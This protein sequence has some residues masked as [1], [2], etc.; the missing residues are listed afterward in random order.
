[1]RGRQAKAARA[2]TCS[3]RVPG[4]AAHTLLEGQSDHQ[5]SAARARRPPPSPCP[6]RPRR[7]NEK[8]SSAAPRGS[9]RWRQRTAAA[10]TEPAVGGEGQVREGPWEVQHGDAQSVTVGGACAT[11]TARRHARVQTHTQPGAQQCPT[12]TVPS[13][14]RPPTH[15][16]ALVVGLSKGGRRL[17]HA[18]EQVQGL[19]RGGG[20]GGGH[21]R[22]CD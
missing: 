13:I 17:H 8:D 4:A 3:G 22:A 14:R 5:R 21:M 1:M 16:G 11:Q 7:Q 19:G 20:G 18:I 2:G 9:R 12:T 10:G 15:R 6:C